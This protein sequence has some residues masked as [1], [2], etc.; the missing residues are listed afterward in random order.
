MAS[1]IE[2]AITQDPL[3]EQVFVL[4]DGRPCLSAAISLN[5]Q[6]W[7]SFASK[8]GLDPQVTNSRDAVKM[9]LQRIG[10]FLSDLPAYAQVRRV[11]LVLEPWTVQQGLLTPTLKVKRR[12]VEEKYREEIDLLYADLKG[13]RERPKEALDCMAHVKVARGAAPRSTDSER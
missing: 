1:T 3:F 13:D 12:A 6:A 4:G 8:F 10:D 9:V 11:H 2:A 5:V 7:D